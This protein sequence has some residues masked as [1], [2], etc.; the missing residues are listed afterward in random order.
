MLTIIAPVYG[1]LVLSNGIEPEC[2][3]CGFNDLGLLLFGGIVAAILCGI[4]FS[5]IRL[6]LQGKK[7]Q[8]SDFVSIRPGN[9]Q[10]RGPGL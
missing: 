4:G 6:R 10:D 1:L 5:L 3:D 2:P 9:A 8:S 7:E